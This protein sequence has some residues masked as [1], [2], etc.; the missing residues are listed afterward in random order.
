MIL[1]SG[2]PLLEFAPLL[3]VFLAPYSDVGSVLTT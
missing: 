2:R 3:A 1:D